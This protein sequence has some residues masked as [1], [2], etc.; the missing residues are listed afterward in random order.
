MENKTRT[1]DALPI[2]AALGFVGI[3]GTATTEGCIIPDHGIVVLKDGFKWCANAEGAQAWN[4]GP[5][6]A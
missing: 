2:L 4:G 3:L 5:A 6:N 1:Q